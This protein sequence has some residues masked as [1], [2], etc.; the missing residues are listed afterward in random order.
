MAN[1][2]SKIKLTEPQKLWLG[3]I[4]SKLRNGEPVSARAL[5]VEL[6]D[7]LP[8]DFNPSDIDSRLLRHEDQITLLGIGLL[9]PDSDLV[10]KADIVILSI[11]ELLLG[12]PKIKSIAASYVS[13]D[14]TLPDVEVAIIFKKLAHI[15]VYHDSGTNYGYG[16]DGWLTINIDAR[17]FDSYL[18]YEN[19]EQIL[20]S[21]V[22]TQSIIANQSSDNAVDNQSA[23]Y[24]NELYNKVKI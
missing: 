21:I 9:D 1:N 10:K 22:E 20:D 17:T 19:L 2:V 18:K 15:G 11:R 14:I 13:S 16:V 6:R 7:K 4:C 24:A 12:N 23:K 8:R 3:A 5:K